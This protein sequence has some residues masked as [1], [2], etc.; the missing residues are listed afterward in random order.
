MDVFFFFLPPPATPALLPPSS[1]S[2]SL[3]HCRRPLLLLPR[4]CVCLARMSWI[5]IRAERW[6]DRDA[7]V[8][9]GSE[10]S[11]PFNERQGAI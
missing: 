11:R 1:F 10:V 5:A 7:A 2:A 3:C 8:G 4:G 9:E 6:R